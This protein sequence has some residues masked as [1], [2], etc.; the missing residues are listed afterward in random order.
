[1]NPN[2]TNATTA[3]MTN[4]KGMRLSTGGNNHNISSSYL[5]QAS[6]SKAYSHANI[7][8]N[9]SSS[10]NNPNTISSN[11]SSFNNPAI[12]NGVDLPSSVPSSS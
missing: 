6:H 11:I 3:N 4:T 12:A 8:L 9:A 10:V 5:Q 1:M 2:A 7:N